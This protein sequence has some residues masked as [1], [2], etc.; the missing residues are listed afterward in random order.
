MSPSMGWNR[1]SVGLFG[2]SYA[3][4]APGGA[5]SDFGMQG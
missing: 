4:M 2:F 3:Q 1:L 5:K